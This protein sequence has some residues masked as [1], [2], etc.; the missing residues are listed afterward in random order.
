MACSEAGVHTAV[1]GSS[2]HS[3]ATTSSLENQILSV[4]TLFRRLLEQL[5]AAL[6]ESMNAFVNSLDFVVCLIHLLLG[7]LLHRIKSTLI[8]AVPPVVMFS[9]AVAAT[10]TPQQSVCPF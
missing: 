2:I 4:D 8:V 7:C 10:P 5:D 3:R 1:A 6:H 9:V